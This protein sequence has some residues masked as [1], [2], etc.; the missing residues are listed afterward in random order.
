MDSEY[1]VFMQEVTAEILPGADVVV[2]GGGTAGVVAALAAARVGAKVVLIERYGYLGGMITAGNAGLTMYTQYSGDAGEHAR[3]EETL[4]SDPSGIQ[5]VG[6]IVREITERL[7]DSGMGKGNAGTFGSY[8]FTSS[9]DFKRLLFQMI[10]EYGVILRLHS[11]AVN[12]VKKGNSITGVIVESKSGRQMI[13][14]I[15]SLMLLETEISLPSLEF[16]SALA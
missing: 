5:I 1:N 14:P 4:K 12:V 13:Q 8:V 2:V 16:L 10:R 7:L 3:D 6:G 11:F 9:E 15:Y